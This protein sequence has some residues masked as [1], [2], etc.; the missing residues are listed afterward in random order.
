MPEIT[1]SSNTPTLPISYSIDSAHNLI[2][3]VWQGTVTAADLRKYWQAYLA[4]PQ[5]LALRRTL[6]D[7][8]GADIQFNGRELSELVS[9]VVVPAL[10]GQD[11]RTAIVVDQPVQFGVSRQYQVFAEFFST[12]SIFDNFDQALQWLR[13]DSQSVPP[14]EPGTLPATSS[15]SV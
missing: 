11:W 5:V 8:R 14:A 12:D 6:V 10:K 3:E 1:M 9:T 2:L 15:G 4:D 7:L 13:N